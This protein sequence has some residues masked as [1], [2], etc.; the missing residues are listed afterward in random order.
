MNLF[1]I[2]ITLLAYFCVLLIISRITG[3]RGDN[4]SFFSANRSSTWYVVSFGMI[5]TSLSGVSF[6]SVPGMVMSIDMTYM[7]T[8]FGFFVGYVVISH[9]LLPL[10]YRLK[11]T[12]IYTYLGLRFGTCSYKTGA[13]FFLLSKLLGAATRLYIV[14]IILHELLLRHYHIPFV[15]IVGAIVLFIW[16]YT[17]R[18]GIRTLVWTDTFQTFCLI[19]TLLLILFEA[20]HQLGLNWNGVLQ[21]I[22]ESQHDRVFV[23][24]DWNNRQHFVKQFLSG[25]FITIVMTGLDQDMMQKNLTCRNLREARR[26]M[27]CYGFSFIPINAL[28]LV[29][30]ILLLAL[31]SQQHLALPMA[32]DALLP[33]FAAQGLMG[34]IVQVCF[35]IGIIAAAFSSADS[36]LTALTT[37]FC[38]DMLEVGKR[39]IRQANRYRK[40]THVA[41]SLVFAVVI[42]GF[43]AVN[44]SSVID[45]L[46]V[47]ASYTYG[48]LLGLFAF[49]LF[50]S[51]QVSDC[52]VPILCV[53]SP[54]LCICVK[55][56]ITMCT[57]YE[58]GYEI[59]MLNGLFTFVGLFL[60]SRPHQTQSITFSS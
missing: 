3:R 19:A 1:Y 58:F 33:I 20:C 13:A 56:I 37:C 55:Q 14:C 39:P 46:F 52:V 44:D 7:Q 16:L 22:S 48:P 28:L 40:I 60:C 41:I 32:G 27:Y 21:A 36:S 31:S 45:A 18:G 10:Y 29:L 15:A 12:S 59:L 47:L 51:R 35:T 6:V 57:H 26:N 11:L 43:K 4:N 30:G 5:G 49:G 34:P 38:I 54:V 42:L 25:A 24:D 2:L 50:T 53:M 23:F 8:V 9:L 17:Y